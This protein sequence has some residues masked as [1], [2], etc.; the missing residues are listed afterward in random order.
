MNLSLFLSFLSICS[1]GFFV[2]ALTNYPIYDSQ[3]GCGFCELISLHIVKIPA[4]GSPDFALLSSRR[5][6]QAPVFVGQLRLGISVSSPSSFSISFS[7]SNT[8]WMYNLCSFSFV[9]LM[10]NCQK[11]LCLKFS[12]P[13][14]SSK[15]IVRGY[16][17][18]FFG[19]IV[20]FILFTSHE[21]K[22]SYN[23]LANESRF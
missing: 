11:S 18:C 14:I 21:N 6:T 12:N 19:N 20:R 3:V 8:H 22:L 4:I 23:A 7:A 10:H 9:Q 2:C 5:I 13:K 15:P 1:F 17:T 16:A